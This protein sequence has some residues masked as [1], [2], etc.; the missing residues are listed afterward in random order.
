LV[1]AA[2]VSFSLERARLRHL[3]W[4]LEKRPLMDDLHHLPGISNCLT[5]RRSCRTLLVRLGLRVDNSPNQRKIMALQITAAT[6]DQFSK[7]LE[8]FSSTLSDEERT[9][10]KGMLEGHGL[11]DETM[12]Q[13]A[14]G[15]SI[16]LQSNAS[17]ATLAPR[18]DASFFNGLMCW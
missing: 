17:F 1:I 16:S 14:G 5:P 10:F 15:R 11:T 8:Q 6:L 9:L 4:L 2:H 13:V 12:A 7:K 18:L 3:L